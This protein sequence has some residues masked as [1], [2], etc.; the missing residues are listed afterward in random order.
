LA[1][2]EEEEEEEKQQKMSAQNFKRISLGEIGYGLAKSMRFL[3]VLPLSFT[4][5]FPVQEPTFINI[6]SASSAPD[7]GLSG[8]IKDCKDGFKP[9]NVIIS[10]I[11]KL[12]PVH[13]PPLLPEPCPAEDEPFLPPPP[14]I[15]PGSLFTSPYTYLSSSS[16]SAASSS[17]LYSKSVFLQKVGCN[18]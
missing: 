4:F 9:G 6:Q 5:Y 1:D 13:M 3:L 12:E 10:Q 8:S 7:D 15:P 2:L 14:A 11:P 17:N 18:N 16:S